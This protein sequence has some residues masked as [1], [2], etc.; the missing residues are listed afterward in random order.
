MNRQQKRMAKRMGQA[1]DESGQ[2]IATTR[3]P[4]PQ[5]VRGPR[6]GPMQFLRE[7]SSELKK[8]LWPSRR[9]VRSYTAV[10]LIA[11]L[12]IGVMIAGFDRAFGYLNN[13]LFK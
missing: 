13:F 4:R 2:P 7:V 9:E 6:V 3:E 11:L 1:M 12:V 5:S 8:V 10:T